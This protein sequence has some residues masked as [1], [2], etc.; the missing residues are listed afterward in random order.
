[1]KK[2]LQIDHSGPEIGMKK[3]CYSQILTLDICWA[4]TVHS[5]HLIA[6]KSKAGALLDQNWALD[7]SSAKTIKEKTES[8]QSQIISKKNFFVG[9]FSSK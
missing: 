7:F 1:M 8:S 2:G 3:F 9:P 5:G 4:Q 6:P